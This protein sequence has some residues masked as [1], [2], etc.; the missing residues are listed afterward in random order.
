M[1]R[2]VL[3]FVLCLSIVSNFAFAQTPAFDQL[4]VTPNPASANTPLQARS[5]FQFCRFVES[6][7]KSSLSRVG[8]VLTLNITMLP[9]PGIVC[10]ATPPPP[11]PVLIDIGTL[12]PGNYTLIQQPLSSNPQITYPALQTQFVVTGLPESF[13][14]L[15][16]LPNPAF[17]G[18]AL[19]ARSTFNLC[20]RREGIVGTQVSLTGT[21]V[22]LT[23]QMQPGVDPCD[24]GVPPPPMPISLPIG[25]FPAGNY[26]LVQQPISSNPNIIYAP[27]STTFSVGPAL[28]AVPASSVFGTI[29]LVLLTLLGGALGLQLRR[30]A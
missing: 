1:N 17:A 26:T 28:V 30:A 20:L 11:E 6:I 7:G 3:C 13:T 9:R 23:L 19:Q 21:V 24:I 14:G 22:T 16:V 27:L 18:Q 12:E 10:F 29:A 5:M 25:T 15:S 2:I 8:N 4:T